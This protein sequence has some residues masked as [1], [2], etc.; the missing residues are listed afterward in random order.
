[1]ADTVTKSGTPMSVSEAR[2]VIAQYFKTFSRLRKWLDESKAQIERDG[3]CYT[4]FGRKRRLKNVFSQ[5]KGIASHEVRSGIN[6]MVQSLA[7]D[8]NLM[9]TIDVLKGIKHLNLD[10]KVFMLVHDSI[11]AVVKDEHV[12]AYK[13]LL[14]ECTQKDRGFSISGFP[15]GIDQDVGQD[16]SFGSFDK[17]YG[18]Q[19]AKYMESRVPPLPT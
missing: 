4:S 13:S 12:E 17:E 11:V 18:E 3:Y 6:A 15:I 14:A 5:D 1:V 9:A 16:Y 8:V 2:E 10:A 19:Y 7:S